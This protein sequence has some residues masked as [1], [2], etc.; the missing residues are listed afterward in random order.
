[1]NDSKS[2][3]TRLFGWIWRLLLGIY[4]GL[5]VLFTLAALVA[6]WFALTGGPPVRVENNVAL[7]LVPYGRLV[8]QIDEAGQT[9]I[10]QFGGARPTQTLLRD[11]IEALDDGAQ[12]PRIK[13]AV[14]KLDDLSAAG[15]PQLQEL[16]AAMQR[17]RAAGKRIEV[18]GESFD[19]NQYFIAAQADEV[20]L[21]PLGEVLL[22]GYGVYNNYFKDALDK[23]G[24]QVNVFRVGEYKS[25]VE[26][27]IRNDM[28]P[29]ARLANQAWLADL[30]QVYN[31]AV[32]EARKLPP[33]AADRYARGFA[34][35]LQQRAGDAAAYALDAHLV[36][37]VETL[38]QFRKRIAAEV[39][40][41][42]DKISFRQIDADS[43]LRAIRREHPDRAADKIGLVVVQGEIV[44]GDSDL[45]TA[46][47]D[48]ISHLLDE[49]RADDRVKAVVLRVD[50][51]GGSAFAAEQ[52]RRSVEALEDAGKP[53]VVSM[54]T[55]AA[56]GGYWISMSAD[57][58]WAEPSTVTG[59]IGIFG[60]LPTIDQPLAKLGIHTDGVGTTPL[61]GAL[62]IDRPLSPEVKTILQSEIEHGYHEFIAGVA[63]GRKLPVDKVDEIAQGRVWS[64]AAAKSLGLVDAF[65]GLRQ[66]VDAAAKLAQLAPG[67]WR[68]EEF[69]PQRGWLS[70][71]RQLLGMSA[72]LDEFVL[73]AA[74]PHDAALQSGAR[75]ALDWLRRLNDPRGVYAYCF[76]TPVAAR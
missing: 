41:D 40:W 67:T 30:W 2:G 26:P 27:F 70:Q 60:L 69:E 38:A 13:L 21:D 49:A 51:P 29:E 57:Q 28:S 66:A 50:S 63:K 43:Y 20:S 8:D 53:V 1:M 25:A 47:G 48:T 35:A 73:G 19:Q 55:L 17:F 5:A 62:R 42:K 56:S 64:G 34:P 68:L 33:D 52:I 58:I 76:C 44:D 45:G 6:L 23:L 37:R 46:G 32:S 14:F 39:G 12:D 4:R 74:R 22:T 71:I 36:T 72:R 75:T 65:G 9:L 61:A 18:Y 24:V 10:R 31:R 11:L 15:L 3:L 54:S 16:A 59:S 7:T